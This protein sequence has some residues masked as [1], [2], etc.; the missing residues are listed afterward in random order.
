MFVIINCF[1]LAGKTGAYPGDSTQRV[2]L[3]YKYWLY[4]KRLRVTNTLA[5]YGVELVT[6][7]K[8]F[9]IQAPGACTI[10]LFTAVIV[11]VL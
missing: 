4:W 1:H 6:A 10:K 8:S 7:I 2:E 5:Y 9:V 11:A 3:A